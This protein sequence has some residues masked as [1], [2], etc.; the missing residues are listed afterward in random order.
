[1]FSE[2]FEFFKWFPSPEREQNRRSIYT[3]QRRSVVNPMLETFDVA[4][5]NASCSRRNATTVAPQALTLFNGELSNKAAGHLA[6]KILKHA[7][8][9]PTKQIEYAFHE[10]LTREPTDVEREK[11]S[12]MLAKYPGAKGLS[13]LAL[14]LFNTN[15]FLHQE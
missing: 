8:T 12:K 15:E 4:N 11:A 9:E 14:V 3:F 1:M 5:M 2:G 13:Y 6:Q 7:G 10:T